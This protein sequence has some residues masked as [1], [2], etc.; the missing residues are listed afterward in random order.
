[1][2]GK[3]ETFTLLR[4]GGVLLVNERGRAKEGKG[5]SIIRVGEAS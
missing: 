5:V 4:C 1:M 3:I 2:D